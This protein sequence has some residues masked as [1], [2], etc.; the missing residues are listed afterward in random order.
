MFIVT[1]TKTIEGGNEEEE[2]RE[3]VVFEKLLL[4]FASPER[5]G[6]VHY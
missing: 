3:N 4:V 5:L 2:R 6:C 1:I